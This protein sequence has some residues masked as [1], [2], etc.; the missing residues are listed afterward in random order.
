MQQTASGAWSVSADLLSVL[1]W[2]KSEA[3][4]LAA[5]EALLAPVV[6]QGMYVLQDQCLA[7]SFS[8]VPVCL[9]F[10]LWCADLAPLS[11]LPRCLD[12]GL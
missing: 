10:K 11:L 7:V 2:L 4:F 8:R 12:T 3:E 9:V 5:G 1:G 6:L